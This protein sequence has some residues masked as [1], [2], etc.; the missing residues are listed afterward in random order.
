MI[1]RD[2]VPTHGAQ[3]LKGVLHV[4]GVLHLPPTPRSWNREISQINTTCIESTI[5]I[6]IPHT[7]LGN[8]SKKSTQSKT[9]YQA[10]NTQYVIS[11]NKGGLFWN[12]MSL[13][14]LLRQDFFNIFIHMWTRE[15]SIFN[16]SLN[17]FIPF[18]SIQKQKFMIK[19]SYINYYQ[20]GEYS[21]W[22]KC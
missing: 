6:A 5:C 14:M 19:D 4:R 7:W 22:I 3:L 17:L 9:T 11:S 8:L 15:T 2:L 10:S 1:S 21:H 13:R 16:F 20:S 18:R 12:H